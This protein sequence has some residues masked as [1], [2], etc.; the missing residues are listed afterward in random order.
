MLPAVTPAEGTV[1]ANRYRLDAPIGRGAFGEVW[2]AIDLVVGAP[3]ALKLLRE[4]EASTERARAR[5]EAAAL[6][7]VRAPGI[8]QL[9]DEGEDGGRAFFAMELAKG[10][11]FPGRATPCRWD[12]LEPLAVALFE[13]LDRIHAAGIVHRDLK[14]SNVLVDED[15]RVTVLDFG[16]ARR[17]ARSDNL[18]TEGAILGTP[19][20]LAPEQIRG[21]PAVAQTDLYSAGLM[22]YEA[23]AGRPAHPGTDVR[24]MLRSRLLQTPAPLQEVVPTVPRSV[25]GAIGRL[26]EREVDQRPRTARVALEALRG[27]VL[28]A[29]KLP[30]LGSRAPIAEAAD[31]LERRETVRIVGWRGSGRTRF[32]EELAVV[33][34]DR[35]ITSVMI[36]AGER[37]FSS[38]AAVVSSID[39]AGDSLEDVRAAVEAKVRSVLETGAA[40]LVDDAERV[41]PLSRDVVARVLHCGRVALA[42]TEDTD[43]LRAVHLEPLEASALTTLFTGRERIFHLQTDSARALF[44]RTGGIAAHVATELAAWTRAGLAHADGDRFHVTRES[45]DALEAGAALVPVSRPTDTFPERLPGHLTD[46]AGWIELLGESATLDALAEVTKH[47]RWEI[48]AAIDELVRHRVVR[49]ADGVV[50]L[51]VTVG[52]DDV[53]P[54]ERVEQARRRLAETL[55]PGANGRLFH[56]TSLATTTPLE[57]AREAQAAAERAYER[58]R[59]GRAL[60]LI[61]EALRFLREPAGTPPRGVTRPSNEPDEHPLRES[62]FTRWFEIA[63]SE[64]SVAA[65]HRMLYE[66][67]RSPEM[68]EAGAALTE[69]AS[70]FV[71]LSADP[72]RAL[73]RLDRLGPL[74]HPAL[75][76]RRSAI[77]M[78]AARSADEALEARILDDIVSRADDEASGSIEGWKGR[79]AY[80]RGEYAA[81]ASHHARAA[82]LE[83]N[84]VDRIGAQLNAASAMLEAFELDA[85]LSLARSCLDTL[86]EIR[87]ATLELRAEWLIRVARYRLGESLTPDSELL[88]A[89]EELRLESLTASV[90]L[91]EAAF[92][93]RTGDSELARKFAVKAERSWRHLQLLPDL[94]TLARALAIAAGEPAT[95]AEARALMNG[96][97]GSRIMGVGVQVL[98]LLVPRYPALAIEPRARALAETVPAP[99]WSQRIDVLSVSEAL[100]AIERAVA[101]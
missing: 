29:S 53:W 24:G 22:L 64:S 58:G 97:A 18:T 26:L 61:E 85:A 5:R 52:A 77:R 66:L 13:T 51:A 65:T 101:S 31:R 40:I 15:G 98:G 67:G 81:A 36:G 62:L 74:R 11:P 79:L 2:R 19:A 80:R 99:H 68:G 46:L 43:D 23:L 75:E 60:A 44:E 56:L 16:L 34:R 72:L 91:R 30:W 47:P 87:H 48:E 57:L 83:P 89:A 9:L 88:L 42:S 21:A 12:E 70:S 95:E 37:P 38:L 73:D 93:W 28:E 17:M 50:R 35:S 25:G 100:A 10:E 20:Y 55:P 78:V 6:R 41:D 86:R 63:S 1:V 27:N 7:L 4:P 82:E 3:I 14:P 90:A 94:A 76:R 96:V 8:V 33:L 49:R 39:G 32:L 45:I 59:T 69:L 54:A 92:A 84:R 71:E